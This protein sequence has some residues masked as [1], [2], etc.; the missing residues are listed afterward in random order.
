MADARTIKEFLV[1]LGF[2]VDEDAFVR[3]G[4]KLGSLTASAA[5]LGVVVV[6][7]AIAIET[8]SVK[9]ARAFD[10]LY[11][12][13]QRLHSS[14]QGIQGYEFAIESMGGTAASAR[15]ALEGLAAAMRTNPGI[16]ALIQNLTGKSVA[17]RGT[18]EIMGDLAQRFAKMPYFL[19]QRYAQ[20]FG[21]DEQTLW[22]MVH[23]P[24]QFRKNQG[25]P[26]RLYGLAGLNP[27][28]VAERM[29]RF[30]V[31]F[32]R[33]EYAA[34]TL[35][36]AMGASLL[37]V[38]ERFTSWLQRTLEFL[39]SFNVKQT[40]FF[41]DLDWEAIGKEVAFVQH[42]FEGLGIAFKGIDWDVIRRMS[43]AIG[44]F[45]AGIDF[46]HIGRAL[47]LFG[48]TL[49]DVVGALISFWNFLF[50]TG[51]GGSKAPSMPNVRQGYAA[52]KVG[53]QAAG[54]G[55]FSGGLLELVRALEASG[56]NAVSTAGA[57]G[58]YQIKPDTAKQHGFKDATAEKLKDPAYNTRVA[59]K[60][61]D[62][63][64]QKYGGNLE[65]TLVAYNAGPGWLDSKWLAKNKIPFGQIPP[66]TMKYLQHERALTG[67]KPDINF[68]VKTD[69]HVSGAGDPKAVANEVAGKQ[70][71]V[72]GDIVR[73]M[74]PALQ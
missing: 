21:I 29:H 42:A 15:G 65:K 50:G 31:Q 27:D 57:V 28:E 18:V 4:R 51:H 13:S 58:R 6:G 74:R 1:T 56:D 5:E 3:F 30:S 71:R 69:I 68:H 46:D 32:R 39:L 44:N 41:K 9:I 73:N 59:L 64:S 7:A 11:F 55:K 25:E 34:S 22:Q 72:V 10:N 17:G 16:A 35:A 20:T 49:G 12:A 53:G 19:A 36:T 66:E 2:K 14:V 45:I 52:G 37:P 40:G 26:A 70:T 38:A 33:V 67:N 54:F 48:E 62:D 63:L 8:F 47:K 61:L 43:V 24:Q 23:R 60:I